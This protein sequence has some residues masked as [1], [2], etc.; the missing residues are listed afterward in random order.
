[1][2]TVSKRFGLAVAI[3]SGSLFAGGMGAHDTIGMVLGL[4]VCIC[5][6]LVLIG[7]EP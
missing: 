1:M 6:C 7:N 3:M 5:G 4:F 2:M